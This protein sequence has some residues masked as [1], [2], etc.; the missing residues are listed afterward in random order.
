MLSLIWLIVCPLVLALAKAK[1]D[2]ANA[3]TETEAAVERA[4]IAEAN[5]D[6]A[7]KAVFATKSETNTAVK[8]AKIA[9]K[10]AEAKA[11]A[12]A[13]AAEEASKAK[14]TATYEIPITLDQWVRSLLDVPVT[15]GKL[16]AAE[17][18][19]VV[20]E[21]RYKRILKAAGV[22]SDECLAL[23]ENLRLTEEKFESQFEVIEELHNQVNNFNGQIKYLTGQIK[24][25]NGQIQC[26]ED[27]M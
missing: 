14:V 17:E 26:L 10:R 3:Q 2:V 24:F 11:E 23:K 20:V 7:E 5:A 8:R 22:A 1:N 4:K 9:V 25:L 15:E 16:K 18:R 13:E 19:I 6:A 21:A 27:S 12:K